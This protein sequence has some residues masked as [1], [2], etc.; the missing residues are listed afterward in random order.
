ML[1]F[2]FN[3][4]LQIASGRNHCLYLNNNDSFQD[5][6]HLQKTSFH[7]SLYLFKG[8][9]VVSSLTHGC[10]LSNSFP[11][12]YYIKYFL[13]QLGKKKK[14]FKDCPLWL[15]SIS[16]P[17]LK[18]IKLFLSWTFETGSSSTFFRKRLK[19]ARALEYSISMLYLSSIWIHVIYSM[20]RCASALM[21]CSL[22]LAL[23]LAAPLLCSLLCALMNI[24]IYL[25]FTV[26][27]II[28]LLTVPCHVPC[29]ILLLSRQCHYV[30]NCTLYLVLWHALHNDICLTFCFSVCCCTFLCLEPWFAVL[31]CAPC[32]ALMCA[33]LYIVPC[34]LCLT[35][36]L[37]ISYKLP[38]FALWTL[39]W[40]SPSLGICLAV[41][42]AMPC[43][44]FS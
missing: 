11:H 44:L 22:A 6:K 4:I 14:T 34:Y 7:W 23:C 25:V 38:C 12:W 15:K 36:C 37:T 2:D 20:S 10:S 13:W 40:V 41:C 33:L 16:P 8:T 21:P 24:A 27:C 17:F 43:I 31:W 18:D 32:H 30:P 26:P 35:F 42:T 1:Y 5:I 39:P 3:F 9:N 29:Y 19:D 28:I